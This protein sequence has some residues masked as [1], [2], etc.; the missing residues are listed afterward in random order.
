MTRGKFVMFQKDGGS[1]L[2]SYEFNGDMY[3]D[4]GHGGEVCKRLKSCVDET[5][6]KH[7][8]DLF[9]RNNHNYHAYYDN[10]VF[11]TKND[12]VDCNRAY[13]EEWFSDFLY[14]KN[15]DTVNRVVIERNGNVREIEPNDIF[16]LYFG[17]VVGIKKPSVRMKWLDKNSK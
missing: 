7:Q 4:N 8:V 10:C 5:S 9:N 17:T 12:K 2:N 15:S 13:F 14:V 11:D 16:V 6:F 3:Y 1:V